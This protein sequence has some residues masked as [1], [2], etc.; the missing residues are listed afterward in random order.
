MRRQRRARTTAAIAV[1]RLT[2]AFE[3][4]ES[5]REVIARNDLRLQELRVA[6]ASQ[7]L[8]DVDVLLE[9]EGGVEQR[10]DAL[11]TIFIDRI[12]NAPR[13]ARGPLNDVVADLRL[14]A[15][16]Q[17]IVVRKI[18]VPEHVR[19][20]KQIGGEA[21]SFGEI[22]A[23][24]IARKHHLENSRMTHPVLQQLVHVAQAE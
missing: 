6:A 4:G 2:E 23:T 16:E 20:H 15:A 18:R 5:A 22:G 12:G 8:V 3:R 10:L 7:R 11:L 1:R 19:D 24:G 14:A 17:A 9:C 13:V 21:V